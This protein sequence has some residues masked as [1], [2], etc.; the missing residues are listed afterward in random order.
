MNLVVMGDGRCWQRCKTLG[1]LKDAVGL[2][3]EKAAERE[4]EM[5]QL[6]A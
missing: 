1:G 3:R 6:R 2:V 4:R 5:N